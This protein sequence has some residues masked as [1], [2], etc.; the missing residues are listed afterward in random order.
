VNG[1]EANDQGHD[2]THAA[3]PKRE[4]EADFEIFIC[5]RRAPSAYAAVGFYGDLRGA[6]GD[7]VFIDHEA[8]AWGQH[9]RGSIDDVIDG[10]SA[11]IVLIDRGW[12]DEFVHRVGSGT[13]DEVIRELDR[14]IRSQRPLFPV[15]LDGAEKA[16]RAHAERFPAGSAQ[17][18]V[19]SALA[20]AHA[21]DLCAK[22]WRADLDR[23]ATTLAKRV[24]RF[25]QRLI[26]RCQDRLAFQLKD[27]TAPEPWCTKFRGLGSA[28]LREAL[29]RQ[30]T[31]AMRESGP[32]V[33]LCAEEGMGKTFALG[34]AL[35]ATTDQPILLTDAEDWVRVPSFADGVQGL[36]VRGPDAEAA[37]GN[38]QPARLISP[39]EQKLALRESLLI[40]IDGLNEE[41]R[42]DWA[43]L[44]LDAL[45]FITEAYQWR[46]LVTIRSHYWTHSI[47]P[48]LRGVIEPIEVPP[49]TD[50]ECR[51]LAA[52][53]G[54]P[55]DDLDNATREQLRKPRMLLAAA[56]VSPERLNGLELSY[57][58][59]MLLDL[60]QQ[61]PAKRQLSF[62][63]YLSALREI[64]RSVWQR[65]DG[66]TAA[67]RQRWDALEE[68]EF[69]A[70]L[71]TLCDHGILERAGAQWQAQSQAAEIGVGL[72]LLELLRSERTDDVE[73]IRERI[74]GYLC[75]SQD[76][77]TARAIAHAMIAGLLRRITEAGDAPGQHDPVLAALFAEWECHYNQ[78]S[79]PERLLRWLLPEVL[80]LTE[81][82]VLH[83][84]VTWLAGAIRIGLS[85][86]WGEALCRRLGDWFT[87]VDSIA[88]LSAAKN[89][90]L[91]PQQLLDDA[92]RFAPLRAPR[93]DR[94]LLRTTAIDVAIESGIDPS[95]LPIGNVLLSTAVQGNGAWDRLVR[96][97]RMRVQDW[98]PVLE[99]TWSLVA[100]SNAQ[101]PLRSRLASLLYALW[102]TPECAEALGQWRPAVRPASPTSSDDSDSEGGSA[103]SPARLERLRREIVATGTHLHDRELA[104]LALW[105]PDEFAS[106]IDRLVSR[107]CEPDHQI[108]FQ[109]TRL[110][111]LAPVLTAGQSRRLRRWLWDRWPE[112][113][114]QSC[115]L[116]LASWWGLP[117][118]RRTTAVLRHL[119]KTDLDA[120]V[121]RTARLGPACAQAV[122]RRMLRE[123][124]QRLAARIAFWLVQ[125]I[126]DGNRADIRQQLAPGIPGYRSRPLDKVFERWLL[127]LCLDTYLSA[128]AAPL[129]SPCANVPGAGSD[130]DRALLA[131]R[132]AVLA[133]SGTLTA[134][135]VKARC[136][137]EHWHL[138]QGQG[139]EA[140]I[141]ERAARFASDF[142]S[143]GFEGSVNRSHAS[144]RRQVLEVLAA[145]PEFLD[146]VIG[147][148]NDTWQSQRAELLA[149]VL[150][151]DET[152]QWLDLLRLM[153]RHRY[154]FGVAIDNLSRRYL[155]AFKAPDGPDVRLIWD[156]FLDAVEHDGE[157][158]ELV[159]AAMDGKGQAWLAV[160]A[161][162]DP[163]ALPHHQL[164]SAVIAGMTADESQRPAMEAGAT[165]FGGWMA[166]G[167]RR[168]LELLD[169]DIRARD[170]YRRFRQ[171]QDPREAYAAWHMHLTAVD[172][173]HRLWKREDWPP[174][175]LAESARYEAA[176]RSEVEHACSKRAQELARTRF[177]V[178]R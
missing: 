127:T 148:P 111:R 131:V 43:G 77:A 14:A 93:H 1:H 81:R 110:A 34:R 94:A 24:R 160:R 161:R 13:E 22:S 121:L 74:V 130:A 172:L 33:V 144:T 51:Q 3:A 73:L 97:A 170:G 96:W 42:V 135:E 162:I 113:A 48:R 91:D 70:G 100:S 132:S 163:D 125:V 174:R 150:E 28:I 41:R 64:G 90:S 46:L 61:D 78:G 16:T 5:Y 133:R 124:D 35:L 134:E 52:S 146:R 11:V 2:S 157:L 18:I 102:P 147:S 120:H 85:E 167:F 114:V 63:D 76:D 173:R 7:T 112:D 9:W 66:L 141:A 27:V 117:E 129:V 164:R 49:M 176:F 75:D 109:G 168:A 155:A 55:W 118:V 99:P 57:P 26:R 89:R 140:L 68:T 12:L 143:E 101:P 145:D 82:A 62:Q 21:E 126:D 128:E 56:R 37:R 95:S 103:P 10:C 44:L 53:C 108:G 123:Q 136:L 156:E 171:A 87:E 88:P 54:L 59:L 116:S 69:R 104:E 6:F 50:A 92:R 20:D 45:K 153:S 159:V 151:P 119:R 106:W 39:Y 98:W 165:R 149:Y 139:A 31:S 29:E 47:R 60:Q 177:G 58:L 19:I 72:H 105:L 4:P 138:F 83:E 175:A 122:V 17:F 36:L 84:P 142:P 65:T 152:P 23:L 107:V 137:P 38:G 166:H 15:Y 80:W 169:A 8:L 40:V 67:I 158:L 178:D 32:L 154:F 30:L 115:Y 25:G 71:E 86:E 79:E